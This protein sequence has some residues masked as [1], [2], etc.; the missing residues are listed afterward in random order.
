MPTGKKERF[1]KFKLKR[2]DWWNRGAIIIAIIAGIIGICNICYTSFLNYKL[3]KLNYSPQLIV[4]K[5][6]LTDYKKLGSTTSQYSVRA[7]ITLKNIGNNNAHL[8]MQVSICIPTGEDF[9]RNEKNK[10][11]F[12][13]DVRDAPREYYSDKQIYP[14]QEIIVSPLVEGLNSADSIFTLH[15]WFVYK[16][17]NGIIYDSYYWYSGKIIENPEKPICFDSENN[18]FHI[19]CW[20]E[21]WRMRHIYKINVSKRKGSG[22]S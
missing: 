12:A 3:N 13:K 11:E 4:S 14:T 18:S 1:K 22:I 9:L 6:Q 15:F 2:L 10:K 19:Y 17:D 5:C 8:M 7:I 20:W 21:S 16:N